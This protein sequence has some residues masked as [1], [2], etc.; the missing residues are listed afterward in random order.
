M[1]D[2]HCISASILCSCIFYQ[3]LHDWKRKEFG[4]TKKEADDIRVSGEWA[5]VGLAV[6]KRGSIVIEGF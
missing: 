5:G 2:E 3:S 6:M 1:I 4:G